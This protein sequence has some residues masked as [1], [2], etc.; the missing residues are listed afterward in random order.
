[1][2]RA[3]DAAMSRKVDNAPPLPEGYV[4]DAMAKAVVKKFGGEDML[5]KV[6][7][8]SA[9]GEGL[10]DRLPDQEKISDSIA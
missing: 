2:E 10:G 4:M 6:A 8:G 9:R 7:D 3:V 5:E 1:M